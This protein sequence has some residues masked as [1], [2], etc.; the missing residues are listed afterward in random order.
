MSSHFK[1]V[2]ECGKVLTQC[3]C[4]SPNK[5]IRNSPY[6]CT[7]RPPHIYPHLPENC[8]ACQTPEINSAC[9]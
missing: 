2:C 3:R 7:H 9:S 6:P 8:P 5:E 1:V 4:I